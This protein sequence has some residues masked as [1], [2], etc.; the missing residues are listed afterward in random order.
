MHATAGT[1]FVI[2]HCGQ[3]LVMDVLFFYFLAMQIE[4]LRRFEDDFDV[5]IYI[6]FEL[7]F[8]LNQ[9]PRVLHDEKHVTIFVFPAMQ[10]VSNL[11]IPVTESGDY[12]RHCATQLSTPSL[13]LSFLSSTSLLHV[14]SLGA[15]R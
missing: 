7:L 1:R 9:K 5:A 15:R 10:V 12:R 4:F 3:E 2:L 11:D 6:E 14:Q 8:S 13:L